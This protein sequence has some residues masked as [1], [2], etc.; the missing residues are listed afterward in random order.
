MLVGNQPMGVHATRAAELKAKRASSGFL[1]LRFAFWQTHRV[2][3]RTS[4]RTRSIRPK[5][6]A[7]VTFSLVYTYIY[8]HL[9]TKFSSLQQ[10]TNKKTIC[11]NICADGPRKA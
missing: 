2:K 4:T 3:K 7:W 8:F 9:Y 10:T 1:C 5:T 6:S 11:D